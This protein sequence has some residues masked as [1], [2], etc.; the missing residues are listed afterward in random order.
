M[1]NITFYLNND[2]IQ[3]YLFEGHANYSEDKDIVCAAISSHVINTTN[4]LIDIAG[5][6]EN[7]NVFINLKNDNEK[8][9]VSI[10]V[11]IDI[12]DN[13]NGYIAQILLKYLLYSIKNIYR[14]YGNNVALYIKEVQE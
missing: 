13:E 14:E 4:S 2:R 7:K 3:G 12:E 8:D 11:K 9:E 5:L 10:N 6:K 1:T